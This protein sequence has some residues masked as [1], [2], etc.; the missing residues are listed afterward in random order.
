[1]ICAAVTITAVG[2]LW[3]TTMNTP[4]GGLGHGAR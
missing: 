2:E 3:V 4:D 1:M